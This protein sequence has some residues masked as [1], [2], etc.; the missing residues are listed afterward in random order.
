QQRMALADLAGI[1]ASVGY[2][3]CQPIG[4]CFMDDVNT[5]GGYFA[6][7]DNHALLAFRGTEADNNF[8]KATDAEINQTWEAGTLVH[9]GFKRYLDSIWA[10]VTQSVTAYRANHPNQN[11]TITG[12]S[13]GAALATL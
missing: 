8:D 9:S 7:N 5:G 1:L 3:N 10:Q 11:L 6:W 13:L 2:P 4:D 12:H